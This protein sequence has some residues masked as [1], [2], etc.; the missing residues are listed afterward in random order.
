MTLP[1][2]IE[3]KR[4]VL[5]PFVFSDAEAI[6]AYAK[7][8]NFSRYLDL[9]P[10]P[11]SLKNAE[12]FI[13]QCILQK[14]ED[15]ATRAITMGAQNIPIG[16]VSIRFKNEELTLAELGWSIGETYWGN[17]LTTEAV[18]AFLHAAFTHFPKLHKI[19]AKSDLRNVG[20][21]RLMEKVHMQREALMR[22]HAVRRGEWTDQV[23]YATLRSEWE[24]QKH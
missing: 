14:Q 2:K 8:P 15:G 21:W 9:V 12:Q 7:N 16:A 22:Q 19:Y 3:T 6:F 18:A 11:Y 4:L 20:S 13:A 17:G 5:R 24:N 23:W 10:Q 1:E